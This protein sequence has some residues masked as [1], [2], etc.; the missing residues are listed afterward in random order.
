MLAK[1]RGVSDVALFTFWKTGDNVCIGRDKRHCCIALGTDAQGVSRIHM[2]LE[3]KIVGGENV[4]IIYTARMRQIVSAVQIHLMH[5]LHYECVR[6]GKH[7]S[8]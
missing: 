5:A 7:E 2:K 1:C 3:L 4:V 6:H 8:K